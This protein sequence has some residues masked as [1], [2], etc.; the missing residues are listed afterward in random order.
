MAQQSR[1]LAWGRNDPSKDSKIV[2]EDGWKKGQE[3]WMTLETERGSS[4]N[5]SSDINAEE[6]QSACPP[7]I[8]PAS[9]FLRARKSSHRRLVTQ[10]G[11]QRPIPIIDAR[12]PTDSDLPQS[13]LI[14]STRFQPRRRP[15]TRSFSNHSLGRDS[16][17]RTREEAGGPERPKLFQ[18][19]IT[20]EPGPHYQ[21]KEMGRRMKKNCMAEEFWYIKE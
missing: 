9:P 13:S 17:D 14:P 5:H 3:K 21:M 15:G 2:C 1:R 16:S 7:F 20:G 19:L 8:P 18:K 10:H 6:L 4:T 11:F 12:Q